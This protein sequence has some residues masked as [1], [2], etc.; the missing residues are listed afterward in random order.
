MVHAAFGIAAPYGA[1]MLSRAAGLVLVAAVAA[2]LAVLLW[3]QALGATRTQGVA[4]VVAFR[5]ALAMAAVVLAVAFTVAGL[6]AHRLRLLLGALAAVLLVF[7]GSSAWVLLQRGIGA[8]GIPAAASDDL[9]VLSWNTLGDSVPA[10]E[11]A[12]VALA[13]HADVVALPETSAA[14]ARAVAARMRAGGRPVT[15]HTVALDRIAVAR[16]TS[17]LIGDSLGPYRV[18]TAAGDTRV[19]P[20]V[21]AVP[22][23]GQRAPRILA[24]HSVAP[25][26]DEV[27]A[28]RADLRWIADRCR[29]DNTLIAGDFNATVDHLAGL[30]HPPAT[31]GRC[32][33]AA[34]ATGNAAVGTWPTSV[35]ALVGA[36]IDHVMATPNWTVTGFRVLADEDGAG[37]DHRPV[38]ARLRPAG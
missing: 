32:R 20:S 34:L 38:L 26:P 31:L 28:W 21:L 10:A 36:P 22:S 24:V 16:S 19:L 29:G 7:A 9:T 30:G 2:V 25:Q 6:L 13:D 18:S 17:V 35:P 3:P 12:R 8:P 14:T 15:P 37:S 27:G 33:D 4:Q 23:G 5:G 1:R 11:I